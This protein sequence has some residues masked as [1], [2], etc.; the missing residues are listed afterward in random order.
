MLFSDHHYTFMRSSNI[1]P[2]TRI[3]NFWK[4][5]IRIWILYMYLFRIWNR[6]ISTSPPTIRGEKI[7]AQILIIC[8]VYVCMRDSGITVYSAHGL[9]WV[10]INQ[11]SFE[12]ESGSDIHMISL[13]RG[14]GGSFFVARH[15]VVAIRVCHKFVT[16]CT[17]GKASCDDWIAQLD[18]RRCCGDI[19]HISYQ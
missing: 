5:W 14:G 2:V 3:L 1:N 15:R 16:A 17:P 19:S 18:L 12:I 9:W 13:G 10:Y 4:D 7:K 11:P 8:S 6:E